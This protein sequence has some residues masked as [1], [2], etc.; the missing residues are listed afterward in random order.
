MI[1]IIHRNATLFQM[2]VWTTRGSSRAP[3]APVD[4]SFFFRSNSIIGGPTVLSTDSSAHSPMYGELLHICFC[5]TFQGVNWAKRSHRNDQFLRSKYP[6][7]ILFSNENLL[8]GLQPCVGRSNGHTECFLFQNYI[9]FSRI[10][11]S[12][13]HIFRWWKQAFFWSDLTDISA[14]N[15]HW[16]H[17]FSWMYVTRWFAA[18]GLVQP[19]FVLQIQLLEGTPFTLE[20][21]W[22]P[23]LLFSKLN[24]IFFGY[25]D[26]ENILL[27]NENK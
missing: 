7:N 3:S 10:L 5:A 26:P 20:L 8:T 19:C 14:K 27:D 21:R 13:K 25:F 15:N 12:R 18:D 2:F 6:V 11:W 22:V 17:H 4:T 1:G 16:L 23:V 24:T 9:H